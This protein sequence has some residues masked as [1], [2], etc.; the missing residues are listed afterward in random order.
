LLSLIPK[1]NHLEGTIFVGGFIGKVKGEIKENGEVIFKIES[2]EDVLR[3]LIG[4]T[5]GYLDL[6]SDPFTG[7]L[8]ED[9]IEISMTPSFEFS[10][11][12]GQSDAWM[13]MN[14]LTSIENQRNF[15]NVSAFYNVEFEKVWDA[16][17]KVLRNQKEDIA[18]ENKEEKVIVTCTTE[19][20]SMLGS[21]A[22]KYIILFAVQSDNIGVI[23][24]QFRYEKN[25]F[26]SS[27]SPTSDPI[28]TTDVY[29]FVPLEEEL[30]KTAEKNDF[31]VERTY[32]R[33]SFVA[34]KAETLNRLEEYINR[35]TSAIF[36]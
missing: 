10:K 14:A 11:V 12:V 33:K 36:N 29:F 35:E 17:L 1:E 25:P 22:H 13:I 30:R 3:D 7:R 15:Q 6:L 2:Y 4:R 8:R 18:F 24:R 5:I 32:P 20:F 27:F 28:H 21:Y 9:K 34:R 16:A 31:A 19:H 23:V 26:Q